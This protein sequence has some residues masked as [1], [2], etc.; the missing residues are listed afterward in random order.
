[1]RLALVKIWMIGSPCLVLGK[2]YMREDYDKP[3]WDM[4]QLFTLEDM[5]HA[6]DPKFWEQRAAKY[7]GTFVHFD[8]INKDIPIR[9]AQ[10]DIIWEKDEGVE[11]TKEEW[12]QFVPELNADLW[13]VFDEETWGK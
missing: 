8:S 12:Q 4:F 10:H 9:Q 1:M 3:Y 5:K 7:H 11:I 2:Q 13:S 6:I